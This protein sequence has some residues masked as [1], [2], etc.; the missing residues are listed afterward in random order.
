M[1]PRNVLIPGIVTAALADLP[2]PKRMRWGSSDNEFV[3]P[4]H[5]LV[6][7]LGEKVVPASIM[8]LTAGRTTRGHRFM[9]PGEISLPRAD[10]YASLCAKPGHVIADFSRAPVAGRERSPRGRGRRPEGQAILDPAVLD[11]VT[12]TRGMAGCPAR[13]FRCAFSA[14]AAGSADVDPPGSSALFSGPE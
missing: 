13:T 5:W 2:A 14:A 6:L 8:G 12:R 10:A 9:A 4:A 3:R 1:S 7:M 11:E